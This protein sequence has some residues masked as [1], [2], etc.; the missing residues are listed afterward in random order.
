MCKL[1]KLSLYE[2]AFFSCGTFGVRIDIFYANFF[3]M[4]LQFSLYLLFFTFYVLLAVGVV[5]IVVHHYETGT[6]RAMHSQGTLGH[7]STVRPVV[8]NCQGKGLALS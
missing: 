4:Q 3:C 1:S 2:F 7:T 5:V 8:I 6:F